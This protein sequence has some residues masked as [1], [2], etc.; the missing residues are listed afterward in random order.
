MGRAI[1]ASDLDQIGEILEHGRAARMVAPGNVVDLAAGIQALIDDP[2]LRGSL[3]AEARRFAIER[4]TWHEHV[5][6]IVARLQ[7]LV[8]TA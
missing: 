1:V 5:R 8:P 7:E 4:H 3:G 2:G 6:R